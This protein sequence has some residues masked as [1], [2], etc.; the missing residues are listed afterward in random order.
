V[1]A[2]FSL[3]DWFAIALIDW[4]MNHFAQNLY[5]RIGIKIP[6]GITVN[7]RIGAIHRNGGRVRAVG[8][9]HD[10]YL[11][12]ICV[13]RQFIQV[14]HLEILHQLLLVR[15]FRFQPGQRR[16]EAVRYIAPPRC[17]FGSLI[18]NDLANGV[19]SVSASIVICQDVTR[20]GFSNE[21]A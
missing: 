16:N 3:F 18:P 17:Q 2:S 8:R 12:I 15:Y 20:I 21:A 14:V 7:Q 4:I 13:G 1:P 9:A 19:V 6:V 10:R 11:A 5:E